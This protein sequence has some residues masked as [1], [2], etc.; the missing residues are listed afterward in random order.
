MRMRINLPRKFD[1]LENLSGRARTRLFIALLNQKDKNELL[2]LAL[3]ESVQVE[4]QPP[5]EPEEPEV[6]QEQVEVDP[7]ILQNFI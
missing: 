7:S 5:E 1:W 2:S 6:E 4:P 3:G